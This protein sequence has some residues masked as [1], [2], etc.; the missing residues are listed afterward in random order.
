MN[1][2]F[3]T[4][5]LPPIRCHRNSLIVNI[6]LQWNVKTVDIGTVCESTM[7]LP[8]AP[9]V[10]NSL[11]S[12]NQQRV[13]PPNGV[14]GANINHQGTTSN[15][16]RRDQHETSCNQTHSDE[17]MHLRWLAKITALN[18][19]IQSS[20]FHLQRELPVEKGEQILNDGKEA[21]GK[22]LLAGDGI[23]LTPEERPEG[24]SNVAEMERLLKPYMLRLVEDICATKMWITLLIPAVEDGNNFGVAIQEAFLADLRSY[25]T[26]LFEYFDHIYG[27]YFA[28]AKAMKNALKYP[29]LNDFKVIVEKYDERQINLLRYFAIQVRDI[30]MSMYDHLNKNMDRIK[31]PRTREDRYSLY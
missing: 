4:F 1:Q 25:E 31:Q 10:P 27:Y 24:V 6:V 5:S 26:C 11:L 18:D 13:H 3:M 20:L 2:I 28:R 19:L 21:E 9:N 22:L 7:S 12:F 23:E 14:R 30:Y 29:Q 15:C 17:G 8:P 16:H